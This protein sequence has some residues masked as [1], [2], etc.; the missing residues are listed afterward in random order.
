M[1]ITRE[2]HTI[3]G[4]T[5]G[6]FYLVDGVYKLYLMLTSGEKTR[7]L[8]TKLNAWRFSTLALNEARRKGCVYVGMLHKIGKNRLVY[9]THIEEMYGEKSISSSYK[10]QPQ[11]LLSREYFWFNTTHTEGYIANSVNIR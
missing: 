6:I 3:N 10:G 2:R 7:L 4:K 1:V 5:V 9:A 8:D 11:R